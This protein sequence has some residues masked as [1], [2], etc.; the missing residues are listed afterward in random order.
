MNRKVGKPEWAI[1]D[2]HVQIE[3]RKSRYVDPRLEK[4]F[5]EKWEKQHGQEVGMPNGNGNN[6]GNDV[7]PF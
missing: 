2:I 4:I 3:N 6:G 7:S 5:E 1:P